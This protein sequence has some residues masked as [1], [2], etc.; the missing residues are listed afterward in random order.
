M[1]TFLG[2]KGLGDPW[3]GSITGWPL[4]VPAWLLIY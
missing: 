1:G 2:P 3:M 4:V